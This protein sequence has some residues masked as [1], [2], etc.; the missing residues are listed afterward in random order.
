MKHAFVVAGQQLGFAKRKAAYDDFISS[1]ASAFLANQSLKESLSN[2]YKKNQYI[3]VDI[4]Q[5]IRYTNL[6]YD[7][8]YHHA[9][10]FMV[11][12]HIRL[13]A[14]IDTSKAQ[15]REYYQVN[16]EKLRKDEEFKL[17]LGRILSQRPVDK[18]NLRGWK[19]QAMQLL[20]QLEEE[21]NM[22]TD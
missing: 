17:A 9:S 12:D 8:R 3:Q 10:P 14:Q 1:E 4:E 13:G 22:T 6:Y 18:L 21:L 15:A 20:N 11:R 2:Y 19:N 16:W 5:R 7:V